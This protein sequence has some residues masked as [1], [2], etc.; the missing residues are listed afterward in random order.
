MP[1]PVADDLIEQLIQDYQTQEDLFSEDGLIAKLVKAISERNNGGSQFSD[2]DH[3]VSDLSSKPKSGTAS[4]DTQNLIKANKRVDG[5]DE[6][7]IS[8]YSRGMTTR[9][10][11]G[12]LRDT[13]NTNISTSLISSIT[14]S[15]LDEMHEWKN[16]VLDSVYPIIYL[17]ALRVKVKSNGRVT[18]KAIYVALAI[19]LLGRKEV[20][21]LWAAE[22]EGAK[23]WLQILTELKTRGVQDIFIACVDGLAGFPEVIETT[24]PRTQVQVCMVH[25]VRNSLQFVSDKDQTEVSRDLRAIY[26]SATLEGAEHQLSL[27]EEKWK[28]TYPLVTRIWRA[29]WGKVAP[30]FGYPPDI[31]RAIYTTN[32]VESLHMTLRKISKN[33]A[34]FP[35]D[36]A[37]F[38]LF[39][40][41]LKNISQRWTQPILHW[42]IAINHFA[43]VFDGRVPVGGLDVSLPRASESV[44]PTSA[45]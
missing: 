38:K 27:F 2:V 20:L 28:A 15:K 16:R 1:A 25:V 39:Y 10:I 6:K 40:L 14:D 13:Y 18:N 8:L 9:E 11:Q 35:S 32:P 44:A 34:L 45:P 37:V 21:G 36:D 24:F 42:S 33:R 3:T 4:G 17:D 41:A 19:N 26:S 31:R 7:I 43:I 23:F 29:N 22:N 5:M 30:M 12:H